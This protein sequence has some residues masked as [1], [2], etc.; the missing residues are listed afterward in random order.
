MIEKMSRERRDQQSHD[1]SA[2]AKDQLQGESRMKIVSLKHRTANDGTPH[3]HV[4]EAPQETDND[5][6]KPNH[7][8]IGG[9][10]VPGQNHACQGKANEG[11]AL[12]KAGVND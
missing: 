8:I 7:S 3:A 9:C 1:K 12:A 6:C 10:Q 5:T 2:A 4:A 11:Q